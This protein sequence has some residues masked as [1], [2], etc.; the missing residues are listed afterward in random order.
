[1]INIIFSFCDHVKTK[2]MPNN[3]LRGLSFQPLGKNQ[4]QLQSTR[5]G[6][7]LIVRKCVPAGDMKCNW[8]VKESTTRLVT[9]I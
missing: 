2:F 8:K 7:D 9:S 5:L 1:M 3:R 6:F 4:Q